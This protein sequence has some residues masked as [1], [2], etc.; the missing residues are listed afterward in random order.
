MFAAVPGGDS[1]L[2]VRIS[3]LAG[4]ITVVGAIA[5]GIYKS[6]ARMMSLNMQTDEF[7]RKLMDVVYRD[8]DSREGA[9]KVGE[10]ALRHCRD[11][12]RDD[13]RTVILD[14]LSSPE[15]EPG[16]SRLI[17]RLADVRED[18]K[19]LVEKNERDLRRRVQP[20]T[21]RDSRQTADELQE[22]ESDLQQ[23]RISQLAEDPLINAPEFREMMLRVLR[24]LIPPG[25]K[26]EGQQS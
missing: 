6:I 15:A 1:E 18:S 20:Q 10:A 21:T 9:T 11:H 26:P 7:R 25:K 24:D 12:G 17:V 13:L 5:F 3:E 14:V 4:L 2:L 8:F 22:A 23:S 16:M 19:E